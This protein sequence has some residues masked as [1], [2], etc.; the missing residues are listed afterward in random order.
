[1]IFSSQHVHSKKVGIGTFDLHAM[2]C[3]AINLSADNERRAKQPNLVLQ[4]H[5]PF[6]WGEGI[7]IVLNHEEIKPLLSD[8]RAFRKQLCDSHLIK[9]AL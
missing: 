6:S 5:R 2:L 9:P 3:I 1:M 4:I 7:W 8:R